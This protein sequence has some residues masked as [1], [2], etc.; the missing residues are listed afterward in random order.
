[1]M[2]RRC[3]CSSEKAAA[4]YL[5]AVQTVQGLVHDYGGL[6][7]MRWLLGTF[8]AGLFPG[9]NFYLSW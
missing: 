5:N 3:R 6:L 9:V 2:V 8:E 1:M 7:A 4:D